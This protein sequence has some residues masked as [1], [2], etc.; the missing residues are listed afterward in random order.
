MNLDPL[1]EEMRRHSP[2]NF[3]FD[4]PI[5]FV[6]PDGNMPVA[7]CCGDEDFNQNSTDNTARNGGIAIKRKAQSLFNG[8]KTLGQAI[9]N[10]AVATQ[11]AKNTINGIGET[12]APVAQGI[13][14]GGASG[15]IQAIGNQ[16][17]DGFVDG[18]TRIR[19]EE[20]IGAADASQVMLFG[21]AIDI[22]LG[23][24]TDGLLSGAMKTV[25]LAD[26]IATLATDDILFSQSSVNGVSNITNSMRRNGWTGSPVDVVDLG[27]GK[28]GT[29]DNTRVLS[30]HEAGIS[31]QANIHG[32]NDLL[33]PSQATRF[34][35][36][37]GG[38]PSTWGQAY[39]NRINNQKN[40]YKNSASG[41]FIQGNN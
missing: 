29:L 37:K 18:V 15:G 24:A 27:G 9:I 28:F 1:A 2:Y 36:K 3:G 5:F 20:G 21:A 33:T 4:N 19:A 39:Q 25:G 26:N 16:I 31:V 6:D 12:L 32:A 8:L 7:S 38:V 10:P 17:K 35:T 13:V 11:L 14:D 40:S 23:V 41:F 34:T 30:A 22:G